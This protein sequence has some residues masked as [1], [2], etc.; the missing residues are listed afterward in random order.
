M[1][2]TRRWPTWPT[3]P[4]NLGYTAVLPRC[5]NDR[6]VNCTVDFGIVDDS[7]TKTSAN[8][9]R[10]FP[11]HALNEYTG[12]PEKDIPSGVAGSIYTLPTALHDGGDKYYLSVMLTGSTLNQGWALVTDHNTGKVRWSVRSLSPGE[13]NGANS[14]FADTKK[15]TGIVTTNST[16]YSAGPPTYSRSEG[17]LNYQVATTIVGERDGWLYLQARNFEFSAPTVTAKLTQEKVA[18]PQ[19]T[20]TPKPVPLV[21]KTNSC[22]RGKV[23][24]KVTT[25]KCPAGFKKK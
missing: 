11:N 6:D 22:I 24:K 17:T 5:A 7:G 18:E 10:Y 20:I 12:S 4:K 8:F 14:C 13:M 3:Y 21:N 2:A 15:V 16:Q 9:A 19:S 25:A 23:I 1:V